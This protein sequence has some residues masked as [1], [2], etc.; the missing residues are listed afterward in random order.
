[1]NHAGAY[2]VLLFQAT[3]EIMSEGSAV[4]LFLLSCL[5]LWFQCK[6]SFNFFFFGSEDT[7][8]FPS[9]GVRWLQ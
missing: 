9:F 8:C 2:V 3:Y 6:Q 1:M 7:V 4:L 5:S